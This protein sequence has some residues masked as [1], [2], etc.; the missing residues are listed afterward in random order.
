MSA[1]AVVFGVCCAI[2]LFALGI[3]IG[4]QHQ[5]AVCPTVPGQMVV[6]TID[7]RDGQMCVYANSFGRATRK[8]RL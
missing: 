6:S 1:D 7:S 2:G 8:V 3:E 5:A 4:Q